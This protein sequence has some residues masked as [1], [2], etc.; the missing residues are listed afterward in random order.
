MSA[1]FFITQAFLAVSIAAGSP[2][3]N[4][5]FETDR[6]SRAPGYAGGA[7]GAMTGWETEG[8]AGLNP[9]GRQRPFHD[10]GRVPQGK[11]VA[12]IQSAGA[13]HQTVD[14]LQ[15]DKRYRIRLRANARY[16]YAETEPVLGV[17]VDGA[18]VI[19]PVKISPVGDRHDYRPPFHL[20]ISEPFTAPASGNV[21]LTIRSIRDEECALL[22]DD[23]TI[24]SL[25]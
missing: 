8:R 6:F 14:G 10:N 24:E 5:S 16:F 7:N 13:L 25:P 17:E 23:V 1:W 21:R 15:P 12:V 18:E 2:V 22:I 19:S 9:V 20:L 3:E 11:Q 4:G